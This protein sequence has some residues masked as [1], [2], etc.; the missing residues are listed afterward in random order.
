[1]RN[2]MSVYIA[3]YSWA[4]RDRPSNEAEQ[5]LPKAVFTAQVVAYTQRAS[6]G[7]SIEILNA[8]PSQV[9][10]LIATQPQVV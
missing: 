3:D 5:L 8:T 4:W 2:G 6:C 10:T 7:I 1:M 9:F